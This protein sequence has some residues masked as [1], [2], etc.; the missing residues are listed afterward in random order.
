MDW[1][2]RILGGYTK[3]EYM[4]IETERDTEAHCLEITENLN[5]V[6]LEALNTEKTRNREL[7]EENEELWERVKEYEGREERS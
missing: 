7:K 1:M 6:L 4:K 5:N 2:I 3:A